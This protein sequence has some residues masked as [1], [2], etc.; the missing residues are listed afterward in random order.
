MAFVKRE[1]TTSGTSDERAHT[2][3]FAGL[4]AQLTDRDASAR[5]WAARDLAMHKPASAALVAQLSRETEYSVRELILISLARIGDQTALNG[6]IEC[7]RSEDVQLRNEA[8][9]AM[10]SLPRELAP[11]MGGLLTDADPDVRI[12]AVNILESLRHPN[13]EQWLIDV[14]DNDTQVN[15]CATAV[16]LLGE[17]G[18]TTAYDAL[19]RL[20]RRF[21]NEPYIQFATDLALK[22]ITNA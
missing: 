22:R 20:K 17:V 6:L 21:Q 5:R 15:V 2:R 7:L 18:T 13:V 1:H 8:I 4:L 3:D 19:Q 14:I 16:D 11:L 12:L 10:Q 9:E